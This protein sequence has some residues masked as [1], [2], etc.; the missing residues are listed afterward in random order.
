[1]DT[2]LWIQ[3]T[4]SATE[5]LKGVRTLSV[6]GEL[7]VGCANEARNTR[8]TSA[9]VNIR[10]RPFP[11]TSWSMSAFKC[12]AA[13]AVELNTDGS[14]RASAARSADSAGGRKLV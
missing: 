12:T 13:P 6:A 11:A 9:L 4:T 7:T 14:A 8:P 10:R 1:M 5:Q 3:A 2:S